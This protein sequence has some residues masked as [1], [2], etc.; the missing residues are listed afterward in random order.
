MKIQFEAKLFGVAFKATVETFDIWTSIFQM[1]PGVAVPAPFPF[2]F[3]PVFLEMIHW[4]TLF[5]LIQ[6]LFLDFLSIHLLVELILVGGDY[7]PF[8]HQYLIHSFFSPTKH[9]FV[10]LM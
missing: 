6:K 1:A 10:H 7:I 4:K 2:C 5:L 3:S 9:T 8:F